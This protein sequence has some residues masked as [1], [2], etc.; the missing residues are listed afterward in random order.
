MK[1]K[2]FIDTTVILEAI[3]ANNPEVLERIADHLLF[4]SINVL[5]EASYKIITGCILE[6]LGVEKIGVFKIRDEFEK[7]NA[8]NEIKEK[9]HI[10]NFLKNRLIILQLSEEVFDTSKEY[11]VKYKLLPNDALIAATCKHHGIR[12]IAT[13]DEDFKRVD[14][15]EVITP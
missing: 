13:F 9:L 1:K 2:C 7:G 6:S 11:I 5:E 4:T 12:K 8:L 15:L 14:F 10:L 3:L